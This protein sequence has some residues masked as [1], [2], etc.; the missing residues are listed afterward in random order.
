MMYIGCEDILA[1]KI[2]AGFTSPPPPKTK[3][4]QRFLIHIRGNWSS[5]VFFSPLVSCSTY[6]AAVRW[7]LIF[8]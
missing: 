3:V 4:F 6:Y 2:K 7:Q 8:M 1:S 5:L